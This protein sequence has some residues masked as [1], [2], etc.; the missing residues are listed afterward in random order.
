LE[1]EKLNRLYGFIIYG[2]LLSLGFAIVISIMSWFSKDKI[3]NLAL[4]EINKQL[5]NP[6]KVKEIDFSIWNSF[7]NAEI[8]FS[9]VKIPDVNGNTLLRSKS[10][11]ISLPLS[12]LWDQS[13]LSISGLTVENGVILI[14]TSKNGISNFDIIKKNNN[15]EKNFE[16]DIQKAHLKNIRLWVEERPTKTLFNI[17]VR[18]NISKLH[19]KGKV[20]SIDSKL[21]AVASSISVAGINKIQRKKLAL[22]GS[23]RFNPS[24]STIAFDNLNL[25]LN[26]LP[27]DL[28][29]IMTWKGAMNGYDLKLSSEGKN[30][31]DL[32]SLMPINEY[33]KIGS[34]KFEG[35]YTLKSKLV[36]SIKEP[37]FNVNIGI[38]N[39]K[40][41]ADLW[42]FPIT[43]LNLSAQ[44]I[45]EGEGVL[46]I[47]KLSGTSAGSKIQGKLLVKNFKDPY[48]DIQAFGKVPASLIA[49]YIQ[50][51][52]LT[53][54]SGLIQFNNLNLKGRL[55]NLKNYSG[56]AS[57]I[58]N[59][60]VTAINVNCLL[61]E[62]SIL[63]PTG[64]FSLSGNQI[65]FNAPSINGKFNN[66]QSNLRT[67]GTI[68]NLIP[69]LLNPD[70][71]TVGING[72]L[73]T[74][75]IDTKAWMLAFQKS[76]N[77][78]NNSNQKFPLQGNIKYSIGKWSHGK[79]MG[80][81][82]I[83][84]VNFNRKVISVETSTLAMGGSIKFSGK[85]NLSDRMSTASKL[86]LQNVDIKN[87]F[88][89]F[90][91]FGQQTLRHDHLSGR[92]DTRLFFT[93]NWNAAKEFDVNSLHAMAEVN[94]RNG[95][96][97]NFAL[98]NG[99]SKFVH[100]QDLNN[101]RFTNVNNWIEIK[102]R[103]IEIPAMFIQNNAVNLTV[104]GNHT[105]DQKI[106]Y[107]VKVNA[108]QALMNR[109]LAYEP[110]SHP[111][112][113]QNGL[114]NLYYQI[115]GNIPNFLF[116]MNR[117]DAVLAFEKSEEKKIAI[118]RA[119]ELNMRDMPLPL[120]GNPEKFI[121]NDIAEN[122]NN[123]TRSNKI[124]AEDQEEYLFDGNQETNKKDNSTKLSNP[125]KGLIPVFKPMPKKEKA[126]SVKEEDE[127]LDF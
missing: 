108:G 2:V 118:Y 79:I 28:K 68:V 35:H 9:E 34:P 60:S 110:S 90:D 57:F 109:V 6:I 42:K 11:S 33:K 112:K 31:M 55:E 119:L 25:K 80:E 23:I 14:R 58:I 101:I 105:F 71:E 24:A 84:N 87:C 26:K 123:K 81:K 103:N 97:V 39:G 115:Y 113:A 36:G 53:G 63:F 104:A 20:W 17:L 77:G 4:T 37:K 116:K 86:L 120:N 40:L 44:Y 98:L 3:G 1:N 121:T 15:S 122:S 43:N 51:P 54:M 100:I 114:F 29:G 38:S 16:L 82:C 111:Q 13:K 117:P 7:P 22:D 64:N 126:K 92:L 127:F 94:I 49:S 10:L 93:G 91:N 48:L 69:Y 72:S 70:A 95:S 74:P 89:Q 59:G 21:N 73:F 76:G 19:L 125:M 85:L 83:G 50:W 78:S 106:N 56:P 96:L 66:I 45:N 12:I 27:F 30:P 102:N 88:L 52:A 124:D 41:N 61:G 107:Y 65:V 32:L 99:F 62:N 18:E 75:S 47:S 5:I 8:R 67:N 46:K